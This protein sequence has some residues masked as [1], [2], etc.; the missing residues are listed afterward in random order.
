MATFSAKQVATRIGTDAKTLRKFLRSSSSTY[1]AVGQGGRYEFPIESLESIAREFKSWQSG[2]RYPAKSEKPQVD[3]GA[4]LTNI[5]RREQSIIED[6]GP[7]NK[8][9]SGPQFP[10]LPGESADDRTKRIRGILRTE[11]AKQGRCLICGHD[12]EDHKESAEWQKLHP[13]SG[14]GRTGCTTIGCW[15]DKGEFAS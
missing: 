5:T 14:L 6:L 3:S 11:R 7:Y 1:D 2:K 9:R 13:R 15:C 4:A 10:F 12:P 8:K